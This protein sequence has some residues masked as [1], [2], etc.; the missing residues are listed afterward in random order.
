MLLHRVGVRLVV[1]RMVHVLGL[2]I[3]Q[4]RVLTRIDDASLTNL[5]IAV[6]VM[7]LLFQISF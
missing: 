1:V 5:M 4:N 2:I 3:K 7:G 6:S